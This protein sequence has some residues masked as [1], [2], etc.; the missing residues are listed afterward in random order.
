[1]MAVASRKRKPAFSVPLPSPVIAV[2]M[3]SR[4]LLSESPCSD[5]I[6]QLPKS[7]VQHCPS[8]GLLLAQTPRSGGLCCKIGGSPHFITRRF[9]P[10]SSCLPPFLCYLRDY[11]ASLQYSEINQTKPNLVLYYPSLEENDFHNPGSFTLFCPG[12]AAEFH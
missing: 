10:T 6:L 5:C 4:F 7:A 11:A 9:Y 1:M 12:A 8:L 2:G 3:F